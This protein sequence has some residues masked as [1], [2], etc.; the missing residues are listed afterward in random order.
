MSKVFGIFDSL[1]TARATYGCGFWFPYL[2]SKDGFTSTEKLVDTWETFGCEILNSFLY[3][4]S[5]AG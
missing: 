5:R 3:T 1:V 4:L 2:V